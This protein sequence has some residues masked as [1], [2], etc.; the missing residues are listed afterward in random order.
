MGIFSIFRSKSPAAQRPT[1]SS[2]GQSRPRQLVNW[3]SE[4]LVDIPSLG[5]IGQ[6]C[7]S[8]DQTYLLAWADSDPSQRVSGYRTE[9]PGRFILIK[10]T[11]VLVQGRLERPNDGKVAN[12]GVFV[13]N[14]WL[15]GEG[16][17]GVFCAFRPTGQ[18]ILRH[19]FEA[20]LYNNGLSD[21]G[22]FAV[23]QTCASPAPDGGKLT[24]FDLRTASP[25]SQTEPPTGWAV[26]YRFDV[27]RRLLGLEYRDL[28]VFNYS[29]DGQFLDAVRW[30][31]AQIASGDGYHVLEIARRRLDGY[32]DPLD[33]QKASDLRAILETAE[34]RLRDVPA[35]RAMV[36][37]TRGEIAERLGDQALAIKHYEGALALDPKVGVKRRLAALTGQSP[38]NMPVR[39][40]QAR[41]EITRLADAALEL[42]VQ[43]TP[44]PLEI[45]TTS[46]G[47]DF[48]SFVA[49]DVET[50]NPD[51]A[52]IC[53]V[54]LV[55][56]TG[57]EQVW[58]W[59]SL[60]NPE[61]YFD[62]FNV[63]IHR[64]DETMV[65]AAPRFAAVFSELAERLS[66]RVVVSHT[67]F[68]RS[69]FDKAA[70]RNGL[71]RL[72]CTWLDSAKVVRRAWPEYSQSGFAL[73]RVT[74]AMGIAL[75]HHVAAEDAR[76]AGE[77]VV[78]AIRKTGLS[79]A[80]WLKQVQRP[81]TGNRIAQGGNPDGP[82]AGEVIVFTGVL[83]RPR[84]EAAELAARAGCSVAESVT[85][86]TTILV[87]GEQNLDRLAGHEKSL[88][89]AK[90]EQLIQQGHEIRIISELDFCRMLF[91]HGELTNKS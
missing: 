20:N 56:F 21:D 29:F 57:G 13:L 76:A 11:E 41:P 48:G 59:Q 78:R 74:E 14:D 15:L 7:H 58:T 91:A 83:S 25:V 35:S 84:A 9:G 61:D 73:A 8:P 34:S 71:P 86:E 5:F 80:D 66:G 75:Q 62:P 31:Q 87:V 33:S 36:E 85:R 69:A 46:P 50:A 39:R 18:P 28:G 81:I 1:G 60:V 44:V 26:A 79:L 40:E 72:D 88:K 16:L 55:A 37:R 82:L 53:Q 89:H 4:S 23:C 10:G 51:V 64:I 49:V 65:A 77:L 2:S 30:E 54:G 70:E 3:F 24:L 6:A 27:S 38:R 42:E 22:D 12:T 52:S 90:A 19:R 63:A 67:P 17:K 32:A 45:S 68:D 43:R 47:P